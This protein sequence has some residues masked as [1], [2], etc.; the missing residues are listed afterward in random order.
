MPELPEV[1][2]I[3]NDLK[4]AILNKRIV[5]VEVRK[6]NLIK[7]DFKEFVKI[8]RGNTFKNIS[9]IGKLIIFHLRNNKYLLIHLKMTGQ[10]IYKPHL[11]PLLSKERKKRVIAG[12]HEILGMDD[13][14][15][16][17]Y[18][19]VIINFSDK[20]TLYFNDM[21]Q[22]GYLKIVDE[23][24]LKAV[25]SR[26]GIEPLTKNYTLNNFRKIFND[27][28]VN[29][30]NLLLNQKL[31]AGIGN[32]YADEILFKVGIRPTRI[33]G[34]LKEDE[35]KKMFKAIEVIL[36]EAIKYR[37]TTFSDYVDS[38]GKK[39]NFTKL[40]KVYGREGEK[41]KKCNGII[42]KIKIGGRGTRYCSKCQV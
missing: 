25:K 28:K 2:T 20:S 9:R 29:V 15:P 1:E 8:L 5:D 19:H 27:R 42:K 22:F 17:K 26:F 30:K 34:Q 37:G 7:S 21:R 10:L 41:C 32:I 31:I 23:N 3:K 39:G 38:R 4:R 36:K 33:A 6:K 24:E 13:K 14:L 40:L 16:N 18:S 35:I 12:G 11:N